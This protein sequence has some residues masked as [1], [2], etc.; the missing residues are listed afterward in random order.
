MLN[1]NTWLGLEILS[2]KRSDA[3]IELLE[4]DPQS[5]NLVIVRSLIEKEESAKI[6][7]EFIKKKDLNIPVVVIGP[8]KEEP[9]AF[10]HVPNSLE[11]KI[12][13]QSAAKALNIT[14]KDMSEKVVPDLFPIPMVF[15]KILKRSI[16]PVYT[17]ENEVVF[18]K[19]K[20]FDADKVDLLISEGKTHLYVNKLDRLAFVHN[21][22]SEL[23]TLLSSKEISPDEEITA[24]DKSLELLSRK[25]LSIGLNEETI[26]LAHKNMD[27]MKKNVKMYPKLAKLLDRLLSNKSSYLFKHTQILTYVGLHIVKNIDWGNQEQEDKIS[28]IAFFHD[29]CLENDEQGKIKS[30]LEL[31]K[32]NFDPEVKSL[33]E[34][35]AQMAAEFVHKFPHAPMGADQIIRQHHGTLNG[36]GFSE[37]YGNNVSP[38]AVVFIVAE[39]FT[40]IILKNEQG[41]LNRAELIRELK[42]EFPTSRFQKVINTLETLSL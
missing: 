38:M 27:L 41:P 20:D 5:I 36:I 3:A 18:E 32:A 24:A 6:L 4:K 16:C 25:L 23:M 11:I 30:P 34:K 35:H 22:T 42:E 7:I 33:V 12:L 31:K 19:L 1:L 28:F 37:H 2:R 17:S 26:K 9:G 40:R 29:I 10:A 15:F 39:E 21:V 13:I 14:A 8:G